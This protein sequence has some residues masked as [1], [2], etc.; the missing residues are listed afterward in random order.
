MDFWK[1][2]ACSY[3]HN[4]KLNF[5]STNIFL[6]V[7]NWM[8]NSFM[9]IMFGRYSSHKIYI[10]LWR[11]WSYFCQNILLI[12]IWVRWML[13]PSK[14]RQA[15]KMLHLENEFWWSYDHIIM[16]TPFQNSI[17]QTAFPGIITRHWN[18]AHFF[19]SHNF[20]LKLLNIN[21]NPILDKNIKF[22]INMTPTF[23]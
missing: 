5:L 17:H 22:H 15:G 12:V 16:L 13:L 7:K 14:S 20:L 9:A 4:F 8:S 3:H 19:V 10:K 21:D 2:S 18:G 23:T 11:M 6:L 1:G